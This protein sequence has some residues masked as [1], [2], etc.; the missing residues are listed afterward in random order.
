MEE[1][2]ATKPPRLHRHRVLKG[3][4]IITGVSNSEI[5][6]TIRNMNPEGAE[7]KVAGSALLPERFLLYVPVDGL[8]Y[9]C[10][11]RWRSGE[12]AGLKFHGTAPKP[13]WH[14]G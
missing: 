9:I 10:E 1:S 5:S 3:A 2:K 7:L 4:T 12:R 14:Y 11:L 8:A 13:R 6:C